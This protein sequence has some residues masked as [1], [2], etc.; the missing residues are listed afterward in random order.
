MQNFKKCYYIDA[1]GLVHIL[2]SEIYF[3]VVVVTDVLN[4]CVCVRALYFQAHRMDH[5]FTQVEPD[6]Y[7]T[8]TK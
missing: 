2:I 6:I 8:Y 7:A 3:T 5:I 1:R 4:L